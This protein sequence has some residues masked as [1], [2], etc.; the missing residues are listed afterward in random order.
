MSHVPYSHR[1]EY[2][3]VTVHL[4]AELTVGEVHRVGTM[5]N[6]SLKGG[7]FRTDGG[8]A[9]GARCQIQ[10]HLEG[11]EVD[12][13]VVGKVVR[14]GPAGCA[15]QFVEIMGIDSLEHLRN[16]I[17]FN[18][19]DPAQVEREFQGHPGLHPGE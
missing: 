9:E 5:E 8:P 16:I 2:S 7:F 12:V 11:T 6:I 19:H 10:M 15:V 13:R 14:S 1:R 4:K 18:T 3:R 17:L